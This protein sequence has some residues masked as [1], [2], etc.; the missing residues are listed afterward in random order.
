MIGIRA[1]RFV[2]V[3][4]K[5]W[6][7]DEAKRDALVRAAI[8]THYERCEGI[9]ASFGRIVGYV[10]VVKPGRNADLGLPYNI[11]GERAGP[12]RTV[13]RLGTASLSAN[14]QRLSQSIWS[15]Y[16]RDRE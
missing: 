9:I 16:G 7:A 11:R 8:K 2:P 5:I 4:E 15:E 6:T 1:L 3:P 13:P 14:G 10:L 12:I